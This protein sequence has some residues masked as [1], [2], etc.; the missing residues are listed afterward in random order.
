MHAADSAGAS[1]AC[2][3]HWT[4]RATFVCDDCG[5]MWC[6][7]CFVPPSRKRGPR[8]CIDC[9]LIA[10]GVK[11]KGRGHGISNMNRTAKRPLGSF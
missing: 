6:N 1:G 2:T 3:K 7:L 8:R 4:E 10:G 11:M 9:A 5:Q